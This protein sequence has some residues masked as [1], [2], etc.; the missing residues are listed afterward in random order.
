MDATTTLPTLKTATRA[1]APASLVS[2]LIPVDN[3]D[4]SL[5]RCA[6][7]GSSPATIVTRAG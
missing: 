3:E 4:A 2:D 7:T 1:T 5:E 6:M